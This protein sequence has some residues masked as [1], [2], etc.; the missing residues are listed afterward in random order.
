MST[1][2]TTQAAKEASERDRRKHGRHPGRAVAEVIRANDAVR[3]GLRVDLLDVSLS[4]IGLCSR[5]QLRNDEHVTVRLQN[6]I[7]RFRKEVR[8]V[9]RWAIPGGDGTWRVGVELNTPFSALDM[10]MLKRAG[11]DITTGSG[12]IWV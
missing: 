1:Q 4:G 2:T 10:Q 9:V 5:E 8:G 7:Q 12:N 6:V 3:R 11:I